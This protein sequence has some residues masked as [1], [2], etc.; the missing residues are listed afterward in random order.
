MNVKTWLS[1]IVDKAQ[2]EQYVFLCSLGIQYQAAAALPKQGI[3][4]FAYPAYLSAQNSPTMKPILLTALFAFAVHIAGAQNCTGFYYLQNNKKVEMTHYNKKGKDSG[5]S[6][7]SMSNVSTS[8]GTTSGTIQSE[9]LDGKG[10]V[11]ASAINQVKCTGGVMMMDMKMFLPSG[12]QEQMGTNAT[13]NATAVYIEYPASLKE[14]DA[15]KDGKFDME[16]KTSAGMN[17]SVAMTISD[18]KVA[19]KESVT[20]P[21]GT[22]ECYKIT[23]HAK[24]NFKIVIGIPINMDVTE[25]YAP[26]FGV[27]RSEAKGTKSEITS[28]K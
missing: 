3:C 19:G 16:F 1:Q 28:V 18:R 10:K 14:G 15:L 21:A 11:I 7:Y 5:K 6:V 24:I 4:L 12:Q 22:W 17:G 25:W 9:Q 2:S 8:G 26:G 27:V 23:Y 20:T 13:A